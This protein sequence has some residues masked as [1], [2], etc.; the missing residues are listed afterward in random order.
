MSR[1]RKISN[2]KSRPLDYTLDVDKYE[3]YGI[4]VDPEI[5]WSTEMDLSSDPSIN[6]YNKGYAMEPYEMRYYADRN[7]LHQVK[8]GETYETIAEKYFGHKSYAKQIK[9][10]N[11]TLANKTLKPGMMLIVGR[12]PLTKE[13]AEEIRDITYTPENLAKEIL[14]L[15]SQV[16]GPLQNFFEGFTMN[17]MTNE[18]KQEIAKILKEWG[19]EVTPVLEDR[20]PRYASKMKLF[21]K[22]SKLS[23]ENN[24]KTMFEG[25]NQLFPKSKVV[26]A[27]LEEITSLEK[28]GIIVKKAEA[29][30]LLDYYKMIFPDDYAT[31]LIDVTLAKPNITFEEF[32]DVDVDISNESLTQMEKFDSGTQEPLGKPNNGGLNGYDFTTHMRPD[33]PGGVAPTS[34]EV[35]ANRIMS[36]LKKK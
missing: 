28:D 36:K 3:E 12:K 14:T 35:R 13:A 22:I 10:M 9:E 24:M 2:N 8:K 4:N 1:I 19:Y 33:S 7:V 11:K 31:A 18:M 15:W 16:D 23:K 17:K 5:D 6:D 29:Q 27:M 26:K 25:F 21:T 34:Y 30:G 20:T 32:K